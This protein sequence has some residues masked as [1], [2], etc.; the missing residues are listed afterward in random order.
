MSDAVPHHLLAFSVSGLT[1]LDQYHAL[2]V[3][4][5]LDVKKVSGGEVRLLRIRNPWG[6]RYWGGAWVWRCVSDLSI[7]EYI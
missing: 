1:E 6:R 4:E 3:M 2:T 5:W 7:V